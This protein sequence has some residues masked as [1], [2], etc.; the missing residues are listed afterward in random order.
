[1]KSTFLA[2]VIALSTTSVF[3]RKYII[4]EGQYDLSDM[5]YYRYLAQGLVVN[6]SLDDFAHIACM[7]GYDDYK[8]LHVLN[9]TAEGDVKFKTRALCVQT[10]ICVLKM[11]KPQTIVITADLATRMI[12]KV[13]L[14]DSCN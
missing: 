7:P 8:G 12:T 2:I 3:A 1:M 10:A 5:E 6:G 14:P 9:T 11:I 4:T 13:E